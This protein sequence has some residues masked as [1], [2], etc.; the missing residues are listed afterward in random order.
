M[1]DDHDPV[2][3]RCDG[4][5]ARFRVRYSDGLTYTLLARDLA[6]ARIRAF[7]RISGQIESVT[8]EPSPE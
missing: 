6:D 4:P 5:L 3:L 1:T 7:P 8:E 2:S